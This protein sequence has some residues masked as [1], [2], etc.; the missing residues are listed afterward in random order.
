VKRSNFLGF[1]NLLMFNRTLLGK[2]LWCYAYERE[3]LWRLVVNI[4]YGSQWGGWCLNLVNGSY[5]V[6]LWKFIRRG[7][8]EF[9]RF[10][11]LR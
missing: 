8:E 11:R 3:V 9:S 7:W 5:G 10:T 2:W 1:G 6:V 4:K